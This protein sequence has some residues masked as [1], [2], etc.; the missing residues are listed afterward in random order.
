MFSLL[1]QATSHSANCLHGKKLMPP[2]SL[3]L[4][5]KM[6]LL[7]HLRSNFVCI[8]ACLFWLYQAFPDNM[9]L[10]NQNAPIY[11]L[12]EIVLHDTADV[13]I[14][15]KNCA[16]LFMLKKDKVQT[17]Y[18]LWKIMTSPL[19]HACL[20]FQIN[21]NRN[22]RHNHQKATVKTLLLVDK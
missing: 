20:L 10:T 9:S 4:A 17:K 2:D 6:N 5:K 21:F 16:I 14:L 22:F 13:N 18:T 15:L 3:F 19:V 8:L 1:I 11:T 7:I 12:L